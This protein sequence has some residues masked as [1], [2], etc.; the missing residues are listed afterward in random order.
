MTLSQ[1][2][3]GLDLHGGLGRGCAFRGAIPPATRT[4]S[5]G[6]QVHGACAAAAGG[7]LAGLTLAGITLCDPGRGSWTFAVLPCVAR[8]STQAL[9]TEGGRQVP[10][11]HRPPLAGT[12]TV[13]SCTASAVHRHQGKLGLDLQASHITAPSTPA[14]YWRTLQR[15]SAS[16]RILA[17]ESIWRRCWR[18]PRHSRGSFPVSCCCEHPLHG[19]QVGGQSVPSHLR[20][21]AVS[22]D[23]SEASCPSHPSI[24]ASH[25]DKDSST[26]RPEWSVLT[27][28]GRASTA[29]CLRAEI[30]S[31]TVAHAPDIAS[32]VHERGIFS[33]L[34]LMGGQ[35]TCSTQICMG[36]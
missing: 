32:W 30:G 24:D 34:Y 1:V 8:A 7:G 16:R 3:H 6:A 23:L 18:Q 15:G 19:L 11:Q 25:D 20:S 35:G 4:A 26:E 5:A 12:I 28:Q 14:R 36:A 10:S 9:C 29:C 27:E 31:H 33:R 2:Q 22:G 21:T 13:C 17:P